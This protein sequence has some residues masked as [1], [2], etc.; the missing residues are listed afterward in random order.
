MLP[1]GTGNWNLLLPLR[2]QMEGKTKQQLLLRVA[3][4]AKLLRLERLKRLL[5]NSSSVKRK[6][7]QHQLGR[8]M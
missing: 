6:G 3:K 5:L 1:L 4:L 8:G 2:V 7:E